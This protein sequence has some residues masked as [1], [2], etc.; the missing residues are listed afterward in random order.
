MRLTEQRMLSSL[1]PDRAEHYIGEGAGR[2]RGDRRVIARA[3]RVMDVE[4]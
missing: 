1:E 3:A 4:G 2:V